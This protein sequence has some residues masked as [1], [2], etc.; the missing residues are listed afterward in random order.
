MMHFRIFVA[1]VLFIISIG[2]CSAEQP[3]TRIDLSAPRLFEAFSGV[4]FVFEEGNLDC[5]ED[6]RTLTVS[7]GMLRTHYL[8]LPLSEPPIF[9]TKLK[10]DPIDDST[11][12]LQFA[13][14]TC[15]MDID[16]RQQIR[17]GDEWKSLLVMEERR[18]SLSEGER[19]EAANRRVGSLAKNAE[20]TAKQKPI[21]LAEINAMLR[22]KGPRRW[23]FGTSSFGFPFQDAPK[24]CMDVFG[25]YHVRR[26][27]F[28]LAFF[29]P[30]PGELN[31]FVIEG[32]ELD[33]SHARVYLT[34][35]DCRFEFTISQ[36]VK[37]DRQWTA[38]PL[39]PVPEDKLVKE[40]APKP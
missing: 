2:H 10:Y 12:R 13:K 24:P 11:Y 9:L 37:H 15:R 20:E 33:G 28:V 32:S 34:K 21:S 8:G 23:G 38:L 7:K 35:D 3:S 22:G 16:V 19:R 5:P 17:S 39:R 30:L 6:H 27:S 31:R 4:A 26:N 29:A 36:S 14:A 25:E 18:P 1:L 40:A